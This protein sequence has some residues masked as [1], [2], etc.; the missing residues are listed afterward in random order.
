MWLRLRRRTPFSLQNGPEHFTLHLHPTFL[1]VSS[2]LV[3][4]LACS[5]SVRAV[6]RPVVYFEFSL[7]HLYYKWVGVAAKI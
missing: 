5:F 1:G 4:E 7:R 3:Y 2:K 6:H